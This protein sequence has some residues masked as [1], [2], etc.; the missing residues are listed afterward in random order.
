MSYLIGMTF[1]LVMM[2]WCNRAT[3][4]AYLRKPIKFALRVLVTCLLDHLRVGKQMALPILRR[5]KSLVRY[6]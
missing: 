2:Q 4:N 1:A 3:K 5:G 6:E